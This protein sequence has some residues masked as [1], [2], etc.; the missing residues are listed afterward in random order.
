[1]HAECQ[2]RYLRLRADFDNFRK[3][4]VKENLELIK[5]ANNDFILDLLPV[6]D[7]FERGLEAAKQSDSNNSILEGFTL[8][9]SQLLKCFQNV[10]ITPFESEGNE[11]DHNLHDCVSRI[12]S[13]DHPEN[14]I[15]S[16]V[17]R[18]YRSE[19]K[20]LRHAKVVV[21]AGSNDDANTETCE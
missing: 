5:N 4:T 2:G 6:L 14:T 9:H 18:G 3:R 19:D 20:I 10:G 7:D 17:L 12:P 16:E 21:S 15:I 11:F 1:E 13:L 8:V